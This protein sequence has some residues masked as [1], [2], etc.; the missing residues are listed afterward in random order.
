MNQ[1]DGTPLYPPLAI[2]SLL[3]FYIY[4]LQCLPT[5]I[6]VKGELRSWSWA[7]DQLAGMS[8]FAYVAALIVYQG[9]KLFGF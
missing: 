8:L 7:L 6:V 9:G 3:V 4:A 2:F 5:T 1:D